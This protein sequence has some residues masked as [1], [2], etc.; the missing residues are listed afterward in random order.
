[1]KEKDVGGFEGKKAVVVGRSLVIGKPVAMMLLAQNATVTICHSKTPGLA[2][3]CR[4]ADILIADA[5][6]AGLLGA[7]SLNPEGVVLDVGINVDESGN[8]CGDV[9]KED[10]GRAKACSRP[11]PAASSQ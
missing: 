9:R 1:V 8:L 2:D 6:K 11:C 5:C 10:V 4:S 7:N 3:E